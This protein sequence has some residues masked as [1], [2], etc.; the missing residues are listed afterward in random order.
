MGQRGTE[1]AKAGCWSFAALQLC[2]LSLF[3]TS[4]DASDI[5]LHDDNFSS[6]VKGMEQG[7]VSDRCNRVSVVPA[8]SDAGARCTAKLEAEETCICDL[9]QDACQVRTCRSPSCT[10]CA[11]RSP[12]QIAE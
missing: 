11:P 3:G 8:V 6:V 1:V 2:F 5:V 4:Q 9:V 12:T 7:R 10:R